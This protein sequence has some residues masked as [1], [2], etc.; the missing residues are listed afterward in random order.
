MIKVKKNVNL[1]KKITTILEIDIR[2]LQRDNDLLK[3]KIES[4]DISLKV[5]QMCETFKVKMDDLTKFME[6]FINN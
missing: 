6:K 5:C 1:S 3:K 2:V 4:L